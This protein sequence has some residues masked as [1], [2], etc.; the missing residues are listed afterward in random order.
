MSNIKRK[1]NN[2]VS[3]IN[4]NIKEEISNKQKANKENISVKLENTKIKFKMD[5][6]INSI[7]DRCSVQQN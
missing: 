5:K 7:Q 2:N 3:E 6:H 1:E 4:E